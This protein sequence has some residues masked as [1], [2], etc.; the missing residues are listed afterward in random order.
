M[1]N[2]RP[3]PITQ[4]QLDKLLKEWVTGFA[5]YL[6]TKLLNE[7]PLN[8]IVMNILGPP[9]SE[10]AKLKIESLEFSRA[11]FHGYDEPYP[12]NEAMAI[13]KLSDIRPEMSLGIEIQLTVTDK[14]TL[15]IVGL[16]RISITEKDAELTG[17]YII[18]VKE[19]EPNENIP[20]RSKRLENFLKQVIVRSISLFIFVMLK[21]VGM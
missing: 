12:A 2:T 5:Q 7:A 20:E 14:S 6:D 1:S 4:S 16:G 15:R 21:K 13:T 9:L 18:E 8:E 17:F 11:I 10:A 3:E 19:A